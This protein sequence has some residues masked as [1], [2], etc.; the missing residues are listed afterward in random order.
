MSSR[1][2]TFFFGLFVATLL[3]LP[4]VADAKPADDLKIYVSLPRKGANAET[5][6]LI[7]KGLTAAI[8]SV[9]GRVGGKRVR[10]VHLDDSRG[11]RWDAAQVRK[12]AK[13][14]VA[15]DAAVAYVGELNS[16]ATKVAQP[17]LSRAGMAMLAPVATADSLAPELETLLRAKTKPNLFRTIPS[18]SAQAAALVS[19]LKRSRVKRVVLIDDGALYGRS[20]ADGVVRE[21]KERGVRLLRRHRADP[22][23][24]GRGGLV[25]RVANAK[26]QAVI[27]TGSLSS[28][29]VPL[30]R[31]LHRA[32]PKALLFGGDALA[33]DSFA[34]RIGR[35]QSMTRLTR[36][37]AHINPRNR[38]LRQ[39]LGRRPDSVTVFAFDGMMALLRSIRHSK[40]W[41]ATEPGERRAAIRDDLF[42]GR[43]QK[44]AVSTWVVLPNG[45]SSNGVFDAIRL[46]KNRVI[47][48]I[49]IIIRRQASLGR[50]AQ[51]GARARSSSIWAEISGNPN[52][53]T[54]ED[55]EYLV[56]TYPDDWDD[57]L[58]RVLAE[59]KK[60]V[61]WVRDAMSQLSGLDR[62]LSELED[63]VRDQ[64]ENFRLGQLS[65]W[66]LP[67]I[68]GPG[69]QSYARARAV[70]TD[71]HFSKVSH[72]LNRTLPET[73][74]KGAIGQARGAV[75]RQ[76]GLES[77]LLAMLLVIEQSLSNRY[78]ELVSLGKVG[79]P[80][81]PPSK[82]GPRRGDI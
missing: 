10:L 73:W 78:N 71:Q 58:K 11:V 64:P 50:G 47:E 65:D 19:Y 77:E 70:S 25:R 52:L 15:D 49:E 36:P 53:T 41:E 76:H 66:S 30:F 80:T 34:R 40:A 35:A 68:S 2:A 56:R 55:L 29:A 14:A 28:G 6:A 59:A 32:A 82:G 23:G 18:D 20:L 48:P 51:Q 75:M 1:L 21:A 74:T 46:G 39:V 22:D 12:N 4:G 5:S 67:G 27:F 38:R 31:A 54:F 3:L 45:N 26:P 17:I 13:R 42:S 61:G 9:E 62:K 43:F 37:A 7:S 33:H 63:L 8:R 69:S 72:L 24:R 57:F 60:R 79:A 16:E 81:P 44:G